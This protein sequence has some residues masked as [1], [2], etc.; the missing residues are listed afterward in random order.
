M[1]ETER[2]WLLPDSRQYNSSKTASSLF[3]SP[4]DLQILQHQLFSMNIN[5]GIRQHTCQTKFQFYLAFALVLVSCC[6]GIA[7]QYNES[8]IGILSFVTFISLPNLAHLFYVYCQTIEVAAYMIRFSYCSN[9]IRLFVRAELLLS[10]S[11]SP[12]ER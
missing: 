2:T 4:V 9:D 6:F 7:S 12:I 11:S 1:R 3:F 10:S 8:K 5:I